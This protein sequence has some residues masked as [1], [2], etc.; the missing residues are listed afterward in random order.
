MPDTTLTINHA[1]GGSE[2]YT[3][4]RDK[5]EGIRN[6]TRNLGKT[7]A[8]ADPENITSFVW[9]GN[10]FTKQSAT[11]FTSGSGGL[12]KKFAQDF[13]G[14]WDYGEENDPFEILWIAAQVTDF[15]WEV[16]SW[17][18]GEA[19][20]APEPTPE[21]FS[22]F[23]GGSI[24]DTLVDETDTVSV[25]HTPP[26]DLRNLLID[27]QNITIN[28]DKGEEIRTLF[29]DG[30][31]V[32]ID[33]TGEVVVKRLLDLFTGAAAAYSL[34][35][36][37]GTA[38]QA[39]INARRGSDGVE[40]DVYP[41]NTNNREVSASSPITVT[42]GSSTAT[43]L[44]EFLT[45]DVVIRTSD[46]SSSADGFIT[47][48]SDTIT[49]NEDGIGG[50]D[51]N[52]S[53]TAGDATGQ[54]L[55]LNAATVAGKEYKISVRYFIPES[56]GGSYSEVTI[57]DGATIKIATDS[58]PSTGSWIT[59][60]GTATYT[61]SQIR[62]QFTG[63]SVVGDKVYIR[64]FSITETK[65]DA[66]VTTWYDQSGNGNDATQTLDDAQPKIAEAGSLL[67]DG[68][69]F[70]GVDDFLET[71]NSDLSNI[72][73]LSLFTVLKPLTGLDTNVAVSAGSTVAS[74]AYGG[75]K[76]NLNGYTLDRAELQTQAKGSA[77]VTSVHKTYTSNVS[78][79]SAI[80]NGTNATVSVNGVAGTASTSMVTPQNNGPDVRRLRIGCQFTFQ[81]ANHHVGGIKE[82]V[83]YDSDQSANRVAIEANING[84]YSIY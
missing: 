14:V 84:R 26:E 59:L 49:F 82:V 78:L 41:D 11:L 70:D 64:E 80:L 75:W 31:E 36:L 74:T 48:S 45:E 54:T 38:D 60:E 44:G 46:F 67:T 35:S 29:I 62:I 20:A 37:K 33:R 42:G 39:L 32:T 73:E 6:M 79:I 21:A 50:L 16:T 3:I 8:P 63:T 5:F 52:L 1:D 40:V 9:N 4:N 22:N 2:T 25:D 57:R 19:G 66:T 51:D 18:Q 61:S 65:Q 28:R 34:Q 55:G 23:V 83:L 58:S 30:V 69:D 15:P 7:L 24:T 72:S 71:N 53:S 27:A 47:L 81:P 76:L 56:N 77:T 43:T 13:G 17:S 68:I 10:T 12:Y